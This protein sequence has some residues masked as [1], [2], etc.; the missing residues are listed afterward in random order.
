VKKYGSIEKIL[1]SDEMK[2]TDKWTV[3]DDFLANFKSAREF[4]QNP[5]VH[6]RACRRLASHLS[7][8]APNHS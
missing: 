7:S 1:E 8:P 2:K 5:D 4:F 3:P 6:Q